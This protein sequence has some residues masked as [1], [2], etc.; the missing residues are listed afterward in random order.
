MEGY[1]RTV[2]EIS[3]AALQNN[4][5]LAKQ[6]LAPSK[7]Q[8]MAVLKSDAYGH[9]AA[10]VA[11]LIA[12][13]V[14]AMAVVST[15]EALALRASGYN[16]R[17]VVLSI[18]EQSLLSQAIEEKI[19]LPVSSPE[20]AQAIVRAQA[21][22]RT[23]VRVHIIAETGAHRLGVRFDE[24]ERLAQALAS[25]AQV[26]VVGV[27]TWMANAESVGH[28]MNRNQVEQLQHTAL[29][30]KKR[31]KSMDIEVHMACSAAIF[32]DPTT[33]FD[34]ARMGI[35]LYGYWSGDY[36]HESAKQ[37]YGVTQQERAMTDLQPVLTWKTRVMHLHESLPIG[38]SISY[39]STYRVSRVSRIAVLPVGYADGYDR[40][41]S[42]RGFVLLH[43]QRCPV[44]GR[45][46]M[47]M[48]MVDTT[49]VPSS[50][51]IGDE[52]VLIGAQAS[53]RIT[54]SDIAG[55]TNT[56]PY[57]VLTRIHPAIPRV[58]TP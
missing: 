5:S 7:A 26:R 48:M 35:S 55:W 20:M 14:D 39:D 33:H 46:C 21:G 4:I 1:D 41:A 52:V 44:V 47:N 43:G 45:V 50:V 10:L 51:K 16:G 53:Q 54:A 49:D 18:I 40:Q 36:V 9:C 12:S 2:V 56:I 24:Q 32:S 38:S 31:T 30:W 17:I 57:E 28:P 19:E 34:I 22:M 15:R 58:A 8:L 25:S 27:F 3:A 6:M 23:P 13:Q 11:S 29:W 37:L 42:N